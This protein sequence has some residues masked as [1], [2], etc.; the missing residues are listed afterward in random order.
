L[1][2]PVK[3][4]VELMPEKPTNSVQYP[5]GRVCI[6][7]GSPGPTGTSV[8]WIVGRSLENV[9]LPRLK[10]HVVPAARPVSVKL[11]SVVLPPQTNTVLR[12]A[13]P[14]VFCQSVSLNQM[15]VPWVMSV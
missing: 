1:V 10:F 9:A 12:S 11:T 6:V 13:K 7:N 14:V 8:T 2:G 4:G 3:V 15:F 5:F